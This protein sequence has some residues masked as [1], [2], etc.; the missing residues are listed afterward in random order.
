MAAGATAGLSAISSPLFSKPSANNE[1]FRNA[2]EWFKKVKGSHK[3]VFDAT[4]PHDGYPFI[5]PWV[6]YN[7][8]NESGTPDN[9]M[10]AV[11]VLRHN[12]MPFALE[13]SVWKTYKLGE[14]FGI[15]DYTKSPALR[16]PY[17]EPKNG[18]YPAPGIDG[19]KRLQ[20][21]GVMFCVCNMAITV[22]GGLIAQK[23]EQDPAKV[24]KDLLDAVLPGV[25]VAPSGVWALGRA[26][27]NGCAY[28]Y[29]GG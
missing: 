29:A 28:I 12:A 21:R 25:Q 18:D 10:T 3:A 17:Y 27:E 13:D 11:V 26:Q 22:Y 23:H 14:F 20:E 7:T 9:D 1:V 15:K 5:W 6:F 2:D 19:I 16:N 8:N 4:E 24:R